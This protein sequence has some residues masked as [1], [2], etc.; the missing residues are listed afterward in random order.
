MMA[1]CQSK[2]LSVVL[3]W[4]EKSC[5]NE[6]KKKN[7]RKERKKTVASVEIPTK[8]GDTRPVKDH[9]Y[10][11][12]VVSLTIE[13]IAVL[14]TGIEADVDGSNTEIGDILVMES[15]VAMIIDD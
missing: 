11:L 7:R 1:N 5:W 8:V 3:R 14:P 13:R 2:K 9:Q 6:C 12:K 10:G 15:I 4:S